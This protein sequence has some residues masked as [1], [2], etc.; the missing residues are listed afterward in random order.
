MKQLNLGCVVL[1][2]L[3]TSAQCRIRSDV[4]VDRDGACVTESDDLCSFL[5]HRLLTNCFPLNN[6][7]VVSSTTHCFTGSYSVS[8]SA[9]NVIEVGS[10]GS[11]HRWTSILIKGE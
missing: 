8:D 7:A 9:L 1:V 4:D 11:E 2:P 5:H 10:L 3:L 6:L